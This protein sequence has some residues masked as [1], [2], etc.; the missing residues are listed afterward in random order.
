MTSVDVNWPREMITWAFFCLHTQKEEIATRKFWKRQIEDWG[1][2][3]SVLITSRAQLA[4][5]MAVAV[6]AAHRTAINMLNTRYVL[7]RL[8]R[9]LAGTVLD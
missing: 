5:E 2:D 6:V 4:R 1:G 7:G 3:P 9:F 8:R